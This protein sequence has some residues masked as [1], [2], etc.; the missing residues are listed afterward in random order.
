MLFIT[1][2]AINEDKKLKPGRKITFD[3]NDNRAGQDVYFCEKTGKDDYIELGLEKFFS[4]LKR[5]QR[6]RSQKQRANI[7]FYS[8]I[9][10]P[11]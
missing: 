4:K 9:L 2:R 6:R 3:I 10:K 8:W 1:N 7:S 5:S 11:A